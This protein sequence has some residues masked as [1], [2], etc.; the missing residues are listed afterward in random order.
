MV[1]VGSD[2]I[3]KGL[4]IEQTPSEIFNESVTESVF[5]SEFVPAEDGSGPVDSWIYLTFRF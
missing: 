4:S 5:D 3:A 2:G 1:W